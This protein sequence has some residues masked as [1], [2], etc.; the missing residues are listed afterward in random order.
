MLA[1]LTAEKRAKKKAEQKDEP[2][3]YSMECW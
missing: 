3:V 1:A 2:K